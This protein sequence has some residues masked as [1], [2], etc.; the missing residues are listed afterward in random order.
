MRH[1]IIIPIKTVSESNSRDHWRVAHSRH[2]SQKAAVRWT[3]LSEDLQVDLPCTI[4]LVRCGKRELDDDNLMGALKY[5]RDAIADYL[6]PGLAPGRADDDRR[7]HW[8]YA[9][10]HSAVPYVLARFWWGLDLS[11]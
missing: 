8:K 3:L 10:D 9:Q 2:K 1:E 4:T 11:D 5:V 6:I 7:I